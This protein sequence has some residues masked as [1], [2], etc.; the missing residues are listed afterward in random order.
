MKKTLALI[1]AA[2]VAAGSLTGCGGSGKD[3]SSAAPDS[4]AGTAAGTETGTAAAGEKQTIE[5]WY[6]ASDE[7]SSVMFEEIFDELNASQ[8]QYEFV[9]TGFANK[10]FPDAFATAVATGTMVSPM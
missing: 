3:S 6:H 2:S 9:Y 4:G 1:L 8:D 7:Q 10:D 5:F